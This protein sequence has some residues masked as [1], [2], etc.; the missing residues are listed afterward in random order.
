M[1]LQFCAIH[2]CIYLKVQL[3]SPK[4]PSDGKRSQSVEQKECGK[5][6][7][8]ELTHLGF[9]ILFESERF[10]GAL[11]L[12]R[13]STVLNLVRIGEMFRNHNKPG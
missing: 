4:H 3:T 10:L 13:L 2:K 7:S 5:I 11:Q 6:T 9:Y 8:I 1:F 12:E